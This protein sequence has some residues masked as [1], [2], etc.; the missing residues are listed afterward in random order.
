V[1]LGV[2]LAAW[3]VAYLLAASGRTELQDF[4]FWYEAGRALLGGQD[5]YRAAF[6]AT[7]YPLYY[8]MPAILL[9]VPFALLPVHA[10]LA[11]FV[12]LGSA[13]MAYAVTA[14]HWW[15]LLMLL[16][17]SYVHAVAMGQWSPFLVAAIACPALSWLAVAK[18]NIGLAAFAARPTWWLPVVG[19]TVYGATALLWPLWP[20]QWFANATGSA[21]YHSPVTVPGGVLLLAAA[22]RWRRPE[23][24]LLLA[25]AIFP[26][27]MLPYDLL[28]LA[29]VAR[30][31]QQMMAFGLLSAGVALVTFSGADPMAGDLLGRTRVASLWL[32]YVPALALVLLRPNVGHATVSQSGRAIPRPA[33]SA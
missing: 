7:G 20:E 13:L 25:L 11:T 1:S 12:G 4:H 9:T 23:A 15:P 33:A 29:L 30:T 18:P 2:G 8:P 24:R 27:S 26:S 5:P 14:R 21:I 28:P 16:S 19:L 10:A 22:L 6:A 3:A 31:R 32:V 17:G